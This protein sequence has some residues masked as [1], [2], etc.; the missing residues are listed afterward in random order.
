MILAIDIGTTSLKLGV[1]DERLNLLASSSECA[2]PLDTPD[3]FTVQIDP[4]LWWAAFPRALK[5][6]EFSLDRIELIT[7]AGNSPGFSVMD[8]NGAPLM[9][10][11]LHL[12][13]RA[14]PQSRFIL[15]LIGE[16]KLLDVTGNIPNPGASTAANILW[17]REHHSEIDK[18]VYM[19]G[20]SN[21]FFAKKL[22]GNFGVD[23]SNVCMSNVYDT[24]TRKGYDRDIARALNIDLDKFPPVLE[25]FEKIGDV[26]SEAASATG[27]TQGLPVLMGANDATC[28]ALSA[29]IV[30]PGDMMNVTGT[31]EMVVVCMDKPFASSRYNLKSHAVQDRWNAMFAL[32]TGGKAIEWAYKQL[33]PDM[34]EQDFYG[35]LIPS[36]FDRDEARLPTF[37]PYL[38]GD[39]YSLEPK[40]ASFEGITL[41]TTRED[42]LLAVIRGVVAK[43]RDFLAL[44][45]E[46]LPLQSTVNLTGGGAPLLAP[47]KERMMP[48]F[49]FRLA[50]SGSL[51]GAA[52]LAQMYMEGR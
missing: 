16:E 43:V 50:H 11:F 7:M 29:D 20:H 26:S 36:L 3:D 33:F 18:A 1:Y 6:L 44:M 51:L 12:D 4:E 22:T 23:P 31:T 52:K 32:N 5:T 47:V 10:S 2:Y 14:Y 8:R 25:A 35:R 34:D 45:E 38:T 40:M 39:R 13:R 19:Y 48:Q 46:K 37:E 9:P 27:L 17:I 42:L 30:N 41:N 15:D 21:T 49:E 24:A 28:A